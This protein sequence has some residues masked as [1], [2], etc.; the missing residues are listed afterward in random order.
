MHD[1]RFF[2]STRGQILQSLRKK[3]LC[4]ID[5]LSESLGLTPNAIR[6][7]VAVL[8]RDGLVVQGSVRRGRFKPCHAY[9]LTS[10]GD[11]LFPKRYESLLSELLREVSEADGPEKVGGLLDG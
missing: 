4:T 8:E 9:S 3:R 2:R 6:Q 5:D 11:D 7:H 10:R 1:E